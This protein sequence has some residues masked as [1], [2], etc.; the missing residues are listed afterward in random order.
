MYNVDI[1]L[2]VSSYANGS[3]FG[4][5]GEYIFHSRFLSTLII[6]A[7]LL[8]TSLMHDARGEP[9]G[10]SLFV[11]LSRVNK[12]SRGPRVPTFVAQTIGTRSRH[13]SA[14]P[15]SPPP[16]SETPSTTPRCVTIR[17][18]WANYVRRGSLWPARI[19][20]RTRIIPL[21]IVILHG[22]DW[23]ICDLFLLEQCL[24]FF[25]FT[26]HTMK[27]RVK[28]FILTMFDFRLLC[29]LDWRISFNRK[30]NNFV[31]E[32]LFKNLIN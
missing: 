7:R 10:N 5:N 14:F 11:Y 25:I 27:I 1:N 3:E 16:P 12:R 18:T 13:V 24:L 15:P 32:I 6:V 20:N 30:G 17:D 28:S 21:A 31:F 26:L 19:I 4:V 22:T 9:R 29:K 8:R 23:K 2:S